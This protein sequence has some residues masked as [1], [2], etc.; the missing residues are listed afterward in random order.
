M[1]TEEIIPIFLLMLAFH[2]ILVIVA[3]LAEGNDKKF[4]IEFNESLASE[5]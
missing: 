2:W 3:K 5:S 1:N 4:Q